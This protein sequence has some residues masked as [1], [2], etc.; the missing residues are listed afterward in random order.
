MIVFYV[1]LY[2]LFSHKVISVYHTV[3]WRK[4]AFEVFIAVPVS[5]LSLG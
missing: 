1:V 3:S 5:T 2:L 4:T